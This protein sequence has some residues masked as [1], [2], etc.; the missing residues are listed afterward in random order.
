MNNEYRDAEINF[1]R[2]MIEVD[3]SIIN[4]CIDTV[5]RRKRFLF[6]LVVVHVLVFVVLLAGLDFYR[7]HYFGGIWNTLICMFCVSLHWKSTHKSIAFNREFKKRA[8]EHKMD[9]QKV[10][11][12]RLQIKEQGFE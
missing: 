5:H 2:V 3:Q 9:L 1:L 8:A 6:W 10:L 11:D 4:H 7:L 12:Q